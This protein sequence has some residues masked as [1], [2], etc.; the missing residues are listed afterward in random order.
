MST[1]QFTDVQAVEVADDLV[2]LNQCHSE[3]GSHLHLSQY[4]LPSDNILI[5]A[6]LGDEQTM[7]RLVTEYTDGE[8]VDTLLLVHSII[9]HTDMVDEIRSEWGD[10]RVI[11]ASPLGEIVGLRDVEPMILDATEEIS[12]R[13]FTFID[14]L[15][16][17]IVV[18]NWVYDHGTET[19]FTAEG[20]GHYHSPGDCEKT[21][22]GID[23]G[24]TLDNVHRFHR[25]R[26]PYL[27]YVDPEKLRT[28]FETLFDEHDIER[29][30]PIHGTPIT[31]GDIDRYIDLIIQSVREFEEEQAV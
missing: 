30:A 28:G 11:S 17:D 12:G 21:S 1:T 19:L 13:R 15:L 31:S 25:D 3:N 7:K 22:D 4:L 24:I 20:I 5:D 18:S 29:I 16:T 26:L 9:P 6:G 8:G 14:P 23:G 27:E 2:W 10:V